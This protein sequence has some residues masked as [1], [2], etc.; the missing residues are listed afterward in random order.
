[1]AVLWLGVS[2][3]ASGATATTLVHIESVLPGAAAGRQ[4]RDG[5]APALGRSAR[6][7]PRSQNPCSPREG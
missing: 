4:G 2:L 1:M 6:A 3:V 5:Q 7:R